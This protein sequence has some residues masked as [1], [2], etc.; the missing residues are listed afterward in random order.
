MEY[1]EGVTRCNVCGK[2]GYMDGLGC[3]SAECGEE[4]IRKFIAEGHNHAPDDPPTDINGNF[5][6]SSCPKCRK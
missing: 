3:C 6:T 2:E 5:D 4:A 1:D